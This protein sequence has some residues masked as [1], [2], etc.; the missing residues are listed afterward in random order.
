MYTLLGLIPTTTGQFIFL[1]LK[2]AFSCLRVAPAS[3]F[4]F[5]FEWE[6]PHTGTK[7]QLTWTRL[8]QGFKNSPALFSGALADDLAEFSGRKLD[9]ILL[10]YVDDL[11]LASTT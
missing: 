7:E 4:L 6:N 11:L 9:W 2:D 3:Q 1:D 10:Q 5:V 8:P